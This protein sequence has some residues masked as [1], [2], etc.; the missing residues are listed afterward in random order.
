MM[1]KNVLFSVLVMTMIMTPAFAT[2]YYWTNTNA[3]NDFSVL[4][5][6]NT[7]QDG[8]G[9]VAGDLAGDVLRINITGANYAKLSSTLSDT[10]ADIQ[11]GTLAGV[12]GELQISGGT[13]T[14]TNAFRVAISKDTAAGI[15]TMTD[16]TVNV[17][18]SYTTFGDTGTSIFN[19]S[20]GTF[21][22]DRIT[23]GQAATSVSTLNMTGGTI[24]LSKTDSTPAV[25]S[26]SLRMGLGNTNLYL[27]GSSVINTERFWIN[28][29]GLITMSGNA[30]IHITGT[31]DENP[32]FNF[33]ED[34]IASM[35]GKI[36][37]NG[38]SF[39]V[40]GD[41]ESLFDAA[42]GN[43]NIYTTTAGVSVDAQYFAGN[44]VTTLV[45]VPEPMTMAILGLGSLFLRRRR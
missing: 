42:I 18:N 9:S 41:Y 2:T 29:G 5:N 40:A 19:M 8:S 22:T 43:G 32:T 10:P 39:V 38:G 4:T 12:T 6:W 1:K 16:G 28:E 3:N 36:V 24:N 23:F 35:L 15:V 26:G 7:A 30:V 45:L 17:P 13:H 14:F 44:D 25:T 27:S 20:G 31:T 33:T 11:I 21:N 37:F 34:A